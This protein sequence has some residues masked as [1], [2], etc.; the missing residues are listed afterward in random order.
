[1]LHS[2]SGVSSV[3]QHSGDRISE[4]TLP[5][6]R[7]VRPKNFN[8]PAPNKRYRGLHAVSTMIP[9]DDLIVVTWW[10]ST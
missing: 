10:D 8:T 2:S 7:E 9:N 1:M 3:L 6:P 4:I 5:S